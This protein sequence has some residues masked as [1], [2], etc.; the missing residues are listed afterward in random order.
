MIIA[1][2]RERIRMFLPASSLESLS[3]A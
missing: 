3:A 2:K 1:V